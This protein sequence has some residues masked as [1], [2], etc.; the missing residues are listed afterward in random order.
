MFPYLD[1]RESCH[2]IRQLLD[3]MP[4]SGDVRE[5]LQGNMKGSAG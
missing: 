3:K 5:K 1:M 4:E 2:I